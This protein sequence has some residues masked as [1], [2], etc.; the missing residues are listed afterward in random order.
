V[1][2]DLWLE[3]GACFLTISTD[4]LECIVRNAP[5]EELVPKY[6]SMESRTNMLFDVPTINTEN[7]CEICVTYLLC[8]RLGAR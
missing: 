2:R 3:I 6:N 1:V 4:K 5:E 7:K 8:S